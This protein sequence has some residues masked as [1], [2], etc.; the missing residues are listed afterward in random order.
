MV[1][2]IYDEADLVVLPVTA[3]PDGALA[4]PGS[5]PV[6]DLPDIG[7]D[8]DD[9]PRGDY[10]T[11]A[12]LALTAL[13]RVPQEPGA[14]IEFASWTLTVTH[15]EHHAITEVRLTPRRRTL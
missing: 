2:E 3:G 7:V 1:G 11:V 9:A 14:C 12:G 13:G 8:I 15:T 10:V 5:F 6:H 4:L